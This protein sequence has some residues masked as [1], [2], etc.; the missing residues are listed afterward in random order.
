MR[1]VDRPLV[2]LWTL[3]Y[4]G[5]RHQSQPRAV[6]A[7]SVTQHS[8]RTL[9]HLLTSRSLAISVIGLGL[10]STV[11]GYAGGQRK[12]AAPIPGWKLVWADEFDGKDGSPVDPTKWSVVT[13]GKGFGNNELE[14]YTDRTENIRQQDGNLVIEARKESWVGTDG[15]SRDYTSARIESR[16]KFDRL[17]GRFEARMKLPAGKGMWPAFWMLGDDI[18]TKGWPR[19]GEIDI[20][21]NIGDPAHIYGTL[22]GPGYSGSHGIQGHTDVTTIDSDFHIYAVDWSPGQIAFSRDGAVYATRK[23]QNLPDGTSWVYDHPFFILLNLAVGG[24][25]PGN[26]DTSTVFPQRLL[27][28]YVRVYEHE[29]KS[30]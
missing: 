2:G 15:I 24:L 9:V 22:H 27:I 23:P 16:G 6:K 28:D 17:Y 7:K 5:Y 10:F 8:R 13:G 19:C 1:I 25:W 20:M 4:K 11:A 21:E 3:S 26:P 18:N 14:T 30:H 29:S 12:P